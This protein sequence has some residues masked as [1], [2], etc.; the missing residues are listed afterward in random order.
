[1]ALEN[2][3]PW[4]ERCYGVEDAMLVVSEAFKAMEPEGDLL[5]QWEQ[6][7]RPAICWA[8]REQQV[9]LQV[10]QNLRQS[11]EKI[12]GDEKTG[13]L[14]IAAAKMGLATALLAATN[15]W[16]IVIPDRSHYH[17]YL[18]P[19]CEKGVVL[20]HLAREE[21]PYDPTVR[22]DHTIAEV[23]EQRTTDVKGDMQKDWL[24]DMI[25]RAVRPADG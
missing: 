11:L 9:P 20:L 21:E 5:D 7:Y 17:D 4:E 13:E 12:C 25:S 18:G 15:I 3:P 2:I 23:F 16:H 24:G 1:M 8:D 19:L 22:F 6:L 10:L 14:L